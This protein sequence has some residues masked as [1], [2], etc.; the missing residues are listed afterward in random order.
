MENISKAHKWSFRPSRHA[1][2]ETV[3]TCTLLCPRELSAPVLTLTTAF[4]SAIA[5]P[6]SAVID[7]S[8]A[9]SSAVVVASA[10]P[11]ATTAT[12]SI[13]TLAALPIPTTLPTLPTLPAPSRPPV[14]VAAVAF[15]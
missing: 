7:T 1:V 15:A 4:A 6:T 9:V 2:N 14:A 11:P 12:L 10:V 3:H 13:T 5:A 8:S